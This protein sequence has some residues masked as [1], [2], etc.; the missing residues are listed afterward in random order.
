M[1]PLKNYFHVN[2]Q[3][4]EDQFIESCQSTYS[5]SS[6]NFDYDK[7]AFK[8]EEADS[9]MDREARG[10]ESYEGIRLLL[11]AQAT[12]LNV[13]STINLDSVVFPRRAFQF[14]STG[15]REANSKVLEV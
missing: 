11:G 3:G 8:I 9:D 14:L 7:E 13:Q 10:E 4:L 2:W 15:D 6:E 5:S 12:E 1:R